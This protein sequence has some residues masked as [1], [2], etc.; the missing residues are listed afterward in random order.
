MIIALPKHANQVLIIIAVVLLQACVNTGKLSKKKAVD[1]AN[2]NARLGASYLQ[3]NELEHAREKLEKALQQDPKNALAHASFAKLQHRIQKD[4]AARKHFELAVGLDP[5]EADHHNSFG[6]FLCQVGDAGE[7]EEQF[8]LAAENPYY[9]T[10]EF[11]L[12]NAGLCMLDVKNYEAA[13]GYLRDA[14]RA[15]P[16]FANA[17]LH[18]AEL[19]HIRQRLTVSDAY[20]Q[21][22]LAYGKDTAKSLWLGLQIKRDSGDLPG[23]Q[24]YASRLLNEFPASAEAGQYLS[25]PIQ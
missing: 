8:K 2:F 7:A 10:P 19:M 21:R 3:R 17:Y 13:E 9:A 23:A 5:D 12:D 16:K 18:M 24:Q 1:A 4:S 6:I 15:N 11:A 14:L 25:R 20:F 22:F